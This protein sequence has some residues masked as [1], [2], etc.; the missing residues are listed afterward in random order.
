MNKMNKNEKILFAKRQLS[1]IRKPA[2]RGCTSRRTRQTFRCSLLNPP[3]RIYEFF[4]F[5]RVLYSIRFHTAAHIHAER[6]EHMN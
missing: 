4:D 2:F 1:E 5:V 6:I 3:H